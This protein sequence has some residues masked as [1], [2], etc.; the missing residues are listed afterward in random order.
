[1]LTIKAEVQKDDQFHWLNSDHFEM[2]VSGYDY[3]LKVYAFQKA[4]NPDKSLGFVTEEHYKRIKE[5]L[6]LEEFELDGMHFKKVHLETRKMKKS[7]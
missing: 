1:M 2:T 6:Y 4:A 5:S 7:L 3:A